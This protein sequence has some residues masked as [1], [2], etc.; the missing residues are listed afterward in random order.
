MRLYS[1]TNYYLSSMQKGIQ[2]AHLVSELSHMDRVN[3]LGRGKHSPSAQFR[4]WADHHKTIV[5]LNGG[6]SASLRKYHRSLLALNEITLDDQFPVVHFQEDS[7]SLDGAWTAVG[8]ILPASVYEHREL[9]DPD[10]VLG[11]ILQLPL[12]V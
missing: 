12:A 9:L 4:K 11:Q 7:D 10:S 8:V 6:N 3:A 1:L 2:T 5:V